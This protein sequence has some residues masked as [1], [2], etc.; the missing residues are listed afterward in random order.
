MKCQRR[1]IAA[2]ATLF[3]MATFHLDKLLSSLSTTLLLGQV[4]LVSVICCCVF[5]FAGAILRLLSSKATAAGNTVY[6]HTI[7]KD[8]LQANHITRSIL[9]SGLLVESVK[10]GEA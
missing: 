6:F 8:G 10:V 2:I 5:A 7:L 3:I 1:L 4:V 9:F